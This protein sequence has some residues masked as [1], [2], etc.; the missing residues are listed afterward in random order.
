MQIDRKNEINGFSKQDDKLSDIEEDD[1]DAI[2]MEAEHQLLNSP[3]SSH[4]S[5]LDERRNSV[6]CV[7]DK[8]INSLKRKFSDKLDEPKIETHQKLPAKRNLDNPTIGDRRSERRCSNG[9]T[10]CMSPYVVVNRLEN[11]KSKKKRSSEED[12]SKYL[13]RT[14]VKPCQ[15]PGVKQPQNAELAITGTIRLIDDDDFSFSQTA[16]E[17]EGTI[18]VEGDFLNM[19][20]DDDGDLNLTL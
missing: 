6:Q 14:C 17:N 11:V 8:I 16:S 20:N 13:Q 2:I 9:N 18:E 19:E 4:K 5:D 3:T 7:E 10:V 12:S 1:D 15:K